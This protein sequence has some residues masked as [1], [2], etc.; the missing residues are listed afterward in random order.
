M[1]DQYQIRLYENDELV[2]EFGDVNHASV[3]LFLVVLK[4]SSIDKLR[5]LKVELVLWYHV[6][7]QHKDPEGY[8]YHIVFM[9]Y[10]FGEEFELKI[11]NL[12]LY[13]ANHKQLW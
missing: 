7:N 13:Y 5:G 2:D 9:I 4:F 3:S 1:V 10:P 11:G 8:A 6:A 12:L